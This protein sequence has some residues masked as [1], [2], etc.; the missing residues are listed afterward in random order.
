[1]DALETITKFFV[2]RVESGLLYPIP[3]HLAPLMFMK[4][5]KVLKGFAQIQGAPLQLQVILENLAAFVG[6]LEAVHAQPEEGQG[7]EKVDS[8]VHTGVQCDN[9]KVVPIVGN[10]YKCTACHNFDLCENCESA[11]VHPADHELIKFKVAFVRGPRFG[12]PFG[13]C[14]GGRGRRWRN[15]QCPWNKSREQFKR[16]PS[17]VRVA[18]P[19]KEG[20]G[21]EFLRDVNI[22]DKT[23]LGRGQMHVKTWSVRNDGKV[24]W[25]NTV[26]LVYASGNREILLD[27]QDQFD[28]PLLKGG[29][30]GDINVPF[31]VP[32]QAGSY[33][34][35]FRFVKNGEE[36]GHHV[37]VE[38]ISE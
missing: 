18:Q 28:V 1:L 7:D 21:S 36:F 4:S 8:T 11:E 5:E 24:D 20:M 3:P 15:S 26:K 17:P 6:K 32:E 34:T 25:D 29:E 35:V 2:E 31:V 9:C 37:W 12:G 14:H 10:R 22:E 19:L 33:K 13:H 23:R 30:T 38:F 27:E 16:E